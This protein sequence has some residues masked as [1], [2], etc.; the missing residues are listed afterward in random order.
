MIISRK[1]KMVAAVAAALVASSSCDASPV[2]Q[3]GN[4]QYNSFNGTCQPNPLTGFPW[5][6]ETTYN[7]AAILSG[8]TT[9][10]G[11]AIIYVTLTSPFVNESGATQNAYSW[12]YAFNETTGAYSL[13]AAGISGSA[14]VSGTFTG[15][16]SEPSG[17]GPLS[18][19]L[20]LN[21]GA[22]LVG[23]TAVIGT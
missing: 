1:S 12:V 18:F 7:V 9:S 13:S 20:K 19:N 21:C 2:I 5:T 23:A 10:N 6:T 17:N 14:T 8:T 3:T 4:V 16:F 22:T 11:Q 15:G